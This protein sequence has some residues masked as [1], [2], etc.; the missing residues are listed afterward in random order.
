[1]GCASTRCTRGS[2]ATDIIDPIVHAMPLSAGYTI[3]LLSQ[4]LVHDL[5]HDCIVLSTSVQP[6]QWG[7]DFFIGRH[8]T[9]PQDTRYTNWEGESPSLILE[10]SGRVQ[11]SRYKV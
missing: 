1:M 2:Y 4:D 8:R 10:S 3:L 5:L 9:C 7:G 11:G 6:E